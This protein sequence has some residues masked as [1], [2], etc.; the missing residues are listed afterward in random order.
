M[1]LIT[2]R[3]TTDL[4]RLFSKAL[5]SVGSSRVRLSLLALGWNSWSG[6][7][8]WEGSVAADRDSPNLSWAS[9]QSNTT[10]SQFQAAWSCWSACTWISAKADVVGVRLSVG[11][12]DGSW[13]MLSKLVTWEPEGFKEF[14]S[15]SYLPQILWTTSHSQRYLC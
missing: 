4:F 15:F 13:A 6:W 5:R 2:Y 3:L 14:T 7:E 8:G 9:V 10:A 11:R 1:F 12:A